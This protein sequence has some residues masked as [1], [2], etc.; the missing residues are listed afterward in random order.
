MHL[1]LPE[2]GFTETET[3]EKV[4]QDWK[5]AAEA[6]LYGTAPEAREIPVSG[7]VIHRIRKY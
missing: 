5:G 4:R 3:W 6:C 2:I 1:R 7:E